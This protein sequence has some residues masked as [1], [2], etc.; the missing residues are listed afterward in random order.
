M[1]RN[2][3]SVYAIPRDIDEIDK[4]KLVESISGAFGVDKKLI[5]DRLR[6][7]KSFIWIKR[8]MEEDP[9]NIINR[10]GFDAVKILRESR[11]FYPNGSLASHVIGFAGVD[12][13]GLEGIELAYNGY[14]NG[15]PG[16][17]W[18]VRDA[19]RRDILSEDV[20]FIPPS[21]GLNVVLTI[22]Q[23]IQHIAEKELDKV[24][25]IYRARAATIIVMDPQTG[26]I[27][28]MANKP[29]YDLNDFSSSPENA[30]RNRAITD[31]YEPGSIFK[32]VA[33]SCALEKKAARMDTEFFCENGKYHVGGRILHDHTPHGTL[34]FKE[35]IEK[36]S[37][38][39][40]TKIAQMIGKEEL[41]RF[42]RLFGFGQLTDIDI[43]GE[44]KGILRT[45]GEWSA[46]SISSVP[47]GQE[48]G[49]TS[50]QLLAALSV[51][52]NG[53]L[54]VKPRVVSK[55]ADNEGNAIKVFRPVISRRALSQDTAEKMK[56]ILKGVVESG[57][58]KKARLNGYGAAGKTG[59]A[60]KVEAN[61]RYSHD[62]FVA[63]FMGFAPVDEP[64]IAIIVSVDEPR[65]VYY[66]GS[67][68]APVFRDVANA[69][70]RY[71]NVAPDVN[72]PDK[73]TQGL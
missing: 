73:G 4:P 1:D 17:R 68:A 13:V 67:V 14:L 48:I 49:V 72:V 40:V 47:I 58:G 54:L 56:S 26:D 8:Q 9:A 51:I 33:A 31:L 53:G 29:A 32:I 60:Q 34:T 52:A 50:I 22:D 6:K 62:K 66:G 44:V 10:L 55:I 20:R 27:L 57:T 21:E 12:D 43:P 3:Y 36:S 18:T 7:D 19:K 35:V 63:S 42:I 2:V 64:R 70:L 28:A 38:I 37:N 65:P 71:L 11:R 61:G 24:Y 41:Y 15:S 69:T 39:G 46:V 23:A 25:K 30:R 5:S 16:W 59:T 45:P